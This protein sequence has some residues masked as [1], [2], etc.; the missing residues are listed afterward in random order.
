M[1]AEV[2]GYALDGYLPID[3]IIL[4][5]SFLSCCGF[6][7]NFSYQNDHEG[8]YIFLRREVWKYVMTG[9]EVMIF[10]QPTGP[11]AWI[12]QNEL[13]EEILQHADFPFGDKEFVVEGSD[14]ED[15][16]AI[17]QDLE[18]QKLDKVTENYESGDNDQLVLD[19]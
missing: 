19:I 12:I 1:E 8:D 13:E 6:P 3:T 7:V 14:E 16:E 2:A 5:E 15:F 10:K 4:I 11:D 9:G 17:G 18:V